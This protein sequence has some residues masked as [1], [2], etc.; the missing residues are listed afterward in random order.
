VVARGET[1]LAG[2]GWEENKGVFGRD[3]G[4]HEGVVSCIVPRRPS[5]EDERAEE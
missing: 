4:D 1:S 5:A 2:A 3:S